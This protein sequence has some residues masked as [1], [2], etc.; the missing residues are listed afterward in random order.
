MEGTFEED[1]STRKPH[2]EPPEWLYRPEGFAD[3]RPG[4]HYFTGIG[5]P[6]ETLQATRDSAIED[7]QRQIVR[8]LGTKVGVRTERAGEAVGDTRGGGYE[9]VTDRVFSTAVSEDTVRG[10]PVRDR[11]YIAG[12]L[13]QNLVKKRVHV[14]YVLVEFGSERAENAVDEAKAE[15]RQEIRALEGGSEACPPGVPDARDRSRLETLRRLEK[16]LE[17]LSADDFGL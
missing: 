12:T 4:A 17:E 14:A 7:A 8:Y 6:R 3:P 1:V 11:Y 5:M 16:R 15:V 2:A 9:A 10:L 13:V